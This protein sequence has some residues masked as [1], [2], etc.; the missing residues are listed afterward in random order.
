MSNNIVGNAYRDIIEDVINSSHIDF[1]DSGVDETTLR[2]LRL[3]WQERLTISGV[4][5]FLWDQSAMESETG[6]REDKVSWETS[7]SLLNTGSAALTSAAL[8]PHSTMAAMRSVQ[9]IQKFASGERVPAETAGYSVNDVM[10]GVR[11]DG[12]G[13]L[14]NLNCTGSLTFADGSCITQAD[15]SSE[16]LEVS[17]EAVDRLLECHILRQKLRHSEHT[18]QQPAPINSTRQ[19]QEGKTSE[20]SLLQMDGASDSSDEES[21]NDD[22]DSENSGAI[23]SDLD[24]PEDEIHSQEDDT[25]GSDAMMLCLYDK[26][27]R[28][29]N[30]WKCDFRDGAVHVNGKD[31]L[32]G[33][34]KGEFEW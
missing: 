25:E 11:L 23:N 29:K 12:I 3:L 1:E 8:V 7:T 26:V 21:N 17:R 28:M 22:N 4:A 33:T 20:F 14:D 34:A 18:T 32:F 6:N 5:T 10:K 13:G 27:K 31:Y 30:Q 15:G 2:E 19:K 9:Q 16:E 24:D